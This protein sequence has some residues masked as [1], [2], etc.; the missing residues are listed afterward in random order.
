[1]PENRVI[2]VRARS[3]KN[4][5]A[6]YISVVDRGANRLPI[7]MLKNEGENMFDLDK[8]F[9]SK[10]AEPKQPEV[11]GVLV[12]EESA[13]G[14][15][16]AMKS[17]DN[18]IFV[19]DTDTEGVKFVSYKQE[20]S[21]EGALIL[22]GMKEESPAV[23]VDTAQKQL[24]DFGFDPEQGFA[25]SV[26]SYGFYSNIRA[27]MNV[28]FDAMFDILETAEPGVPPLE[29]AQTLLDE[30]NAY[31]V[32]LLQT[33]PTEAFKME[34]L[35]PVVNQDDHETTE[36]EASKSE[37]EAIEGEL[38]P[39][40]EGEAVKD[41]GEAV[42]EGAAPQSEAGEA[43]GA[44]GEEQKDESG[45]DQLSQIL[46]Q[47]NNIGST[48][49]NLTQTVESMKSEVDSI[50]ETVNEQGVQIQSVNEG[51][52]KAESAANEAKKSAASVVI[53]T[54]E[55]RTDSQKSEDDYDPEAVDRRNR[56]IEYT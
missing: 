28:L 48:M 29:R 2:K 7:R 11:M 33:V 15:A 1:M 16:N 44:E 22:K 17:D 5:E 36:A 13:Q 56:N 32:S 20:A 38:L 49:Q 40:A 30:F 12:P 4:A 51:V 31:M 8:L 46:E 45:N 23:V 43:K 35:Q 6:S 18:E 25:G 26:V 27:A 52:Q 54:D 9:R 10:K 37:G 14:Y 42:V 53:D 24:S 34:N 3:L 39:G 50:K 19:L 41:E 21:L 55:G 47:M